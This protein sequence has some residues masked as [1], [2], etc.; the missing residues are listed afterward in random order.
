MF[1]AKGGPPLSAAGRPHLG[2]YVAP[3]NGYTERV[4]PLHG[5]LRLRLDV[6]D[7]PS[8]QG[9]LHQAPRAL[10]RGAAAR[11]RAPPAH[12]VL[13]LRRPA[14]DPQHAAGRADR[15]HAARVPA[16]LPPRRPDG[17]HDD[18]EPCLEASPRRCHECFPESRRRP[19]S[20]A[21]GSSSRTS[22]H[23]DLFIAPSQFLLERY[24]DWGIPREKI[25]V[26][27]Y[28]RTPPPAT[29]PS[30]DAGVPRPLR[31]LRAADPVQGRAGPARGDAMRA[32]AT[33]GPTTPV[34]R[35]SSRPRQPRRAGRWREPHAFDPRREPRPPARDLPE[36]DRGAP[37]AHAEQRD[38]RRPLRARRARE[39]DGEHRL[40]VVPSLWWENSPLVIQEAFHFGR[41]VICSDIGGMAEKVTD[42]VNGLHF[43]P[44]TPPASRTRSSP[45]RRSGAVGAAA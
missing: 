26:E 15:L 7:D 18:E 29:S 6:R 35:S 14:G 9:A 13:R 16:D 40:G 36:P 19:S 42:G 25:V 20:C 27:E 17:A 45:Q 39:P 10:P 24:V 1:L 22:T 23:V 33:V 2:T 28:G 8:R 12:D 32:D 41:P 5:R 43:R 34:E 44:A 3:V 11:H 21:S 30:D 4:L 37:R 31:L 38:L